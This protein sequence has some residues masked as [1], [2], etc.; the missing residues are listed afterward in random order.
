MS[1]GTETILKDIRRWVKIIG[2]Q[3]A[4]DVMLDALSDNDPDEQEEL[5]VIYH[6]TDGDT[7]TRSIASHVSVGKDAISSRQ[8]RWAKMGLVEKEH[9][10]APY[11]HIISL[12]EAGIDVPEIPD[13]EGGNDD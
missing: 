4:K 3:E 7:S 5:R 11:K 2:I 10:N 8:Q 9:A 1:N 12:E 6:L 13:S